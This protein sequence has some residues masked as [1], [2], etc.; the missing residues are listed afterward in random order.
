MVKIACW[1]SRV[2]CKAARLSTGFD[3]ELAPQKQASVVVQCVEGL[4]G[5]NSSVHSFTDS[6]RHPILA[7]AL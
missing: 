6:M 3:V 4:S 5:T 7:P 2:L 1:I